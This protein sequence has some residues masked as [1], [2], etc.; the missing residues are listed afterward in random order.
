M[1]GQS[2]GSIGDPIIYIYFNQNNG[3]AENELGTVPHFVI[4]YPNPFKGS[5]R[6][7][8]DCVTKNKI[9]KQ[10]LIYNIKGQ[11]IRELQIYGKEI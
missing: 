10:L 5:I 3:I 11:K 2:A 6:F 1:F 8:V 7:N 4:I 9:N